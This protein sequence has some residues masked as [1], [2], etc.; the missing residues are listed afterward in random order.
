ME[1]SHVLQAEGL[2]QG[3]TDAYVAD[4]VQNGYV[5]SKL[6]DAA[7]MLEMGCRGGA[8]FEAALGRTIN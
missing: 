3:L 6:E 5:G 2:G 1:L 4:F 7:R 8:D